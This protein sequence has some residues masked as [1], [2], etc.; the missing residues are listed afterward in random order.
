MARPLMQQGIGQLEEM[1]KRGQ[2]D[3]AALLQLQDELQHRH[4][5]RAVTLLAEVQRSLQTP[6]TTSACAPASTSVTALTSTPSGI[7]PALPQPD[8][9]AARLAATESP[10]G[11]SRAA[12]APPSMPVADAYKLLKATPGASWESIEM[13]RRTLVQRLSPA[14]TQVKTTEEPAALLNE[15]RRVNEAYAVLAIH[16]LVRS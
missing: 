9:W 2:A 7:A 4:V 10:S 12:G 14:K 11:P 16:R 13:T 1:F 15:A 3:R 5:P 8:L 6:G